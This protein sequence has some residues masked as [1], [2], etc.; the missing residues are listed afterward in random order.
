MW[1]DFREAGFR[2]ELTLVSL[3]LAE[4]YI[5]H[6]TTRHAIRLL[7]SFLAPE[8]QAGAPRGNGGVA[9]AG[10]GRRSGGYAGTVIDSNGAGTRI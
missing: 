10:R 6:G 2:Q 3:D 8:R 1:H 5:A 4:V 9:A 7:K